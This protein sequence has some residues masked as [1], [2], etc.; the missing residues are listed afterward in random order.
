M[1]KDKIFSIKL[2]SI[3]AYVLEMMF[4]HFIHIKHACSPNL[5]YIYMLLTSWH[6]KN[7]SLKQEK[8]SMTNYNGVQMKKYD[9]RQVD[10]LN[11]ILF[12]CFSG[13]LTIIFPMLFIFERFFMSSYFYV[14]L[15]LPD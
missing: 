4:L 6:K 1:S 7:Y 15:P 9:N 11:S 13:K 5:M 2:N 10:V 12:H 14:T 3:R 8:L